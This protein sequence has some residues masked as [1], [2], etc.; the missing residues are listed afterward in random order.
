MVLVAPS[1]VASSCGWHVESLAIDATAHLNQPGPT[2]FDYPLSEPVSM[3]N[4]TAFQLDFFDMT[5]VGA[6]KVTAVI[7]LLSEGVV[8]AN[9]G[10]P[11]L[12]T[13]SNTP[14]T[15]VGRPVGLVAVTGSVDAIRLV[16]DQSSFNMT[17]TVRGAHAGDE[18]IMRFIVSPWDLDGPHQLL[19]LGVLNPITVGGGTSKWED[20]EL[21]APVPATDLRLIAQS[22]WQFSISGG[23]GSATTETQ[24]LFDNGVTLTL[25]DWASPSQHQ[26]A[27]ASEILYNATASLA[28][29][30]ETAAMVEGANMTKWRWRAHANGPGMVTFNPA[31]GDDFFLA[32]M[33]DSVVT[34]LGDLDRDCVVGINDFLMLLAAWGP[35]PDPCPPSCAAD[36]DGDCNVGINDFLILLANW[37]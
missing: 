24:V 26:A 21:P 4:V 1:A 5:K 10:G 14:I 8:V 7:Q 15:L 31:T 35:C 29:D 13:G 18:V 3:E 34:V 25:D 30:K 33:F 36:L 6:G 27:D 37:G 23:L 2:N 22:G 12:V 32:I 20:V 9:I 17:T 11:H 16:I 19:N 28:V